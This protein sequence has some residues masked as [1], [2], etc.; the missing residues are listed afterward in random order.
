MVSIAFA[1][2]AQS[3]QDHTEGITLA[4]MDTNTSHP[5]SKQ[6][7]Q[8]QISEAMSNKTT[9]IMAGTCILTPI[10]HSI[11]VTHRAMGPTNQNFSPAASKIK[12]LLVYEAFGS[13]FREL[14]PLHFIKLQ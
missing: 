9:T 12:R 10:E 7:F 5:L 6:S 11:A 1:F 4:A 14:F 13:D 8:D 3:L 2:D